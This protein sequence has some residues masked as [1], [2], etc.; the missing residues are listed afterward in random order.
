MKIELPV[1][2]L[3][4]SDLFLLEEV[5]FSRC[6]AADG[7]GASLRLTGLA[8]R[9]GGGRWPSPYEP[10]FP[11]ELDA[12]GVRDL[13]LHLLG[14]LVQLDD[15]DVVDISSRGWEQ[16]RFEVGD[17]AARVIH[18]YCQRLVVRSVTEAAFPEALS[19][20]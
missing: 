16:I 14:E 10:C 20:S 13:S 11:V 17:D 18:F 9:R 1:D 7:G 4:L 2:G 8:Q 12:E 15:F 19:G 3:E 6:T 5:S